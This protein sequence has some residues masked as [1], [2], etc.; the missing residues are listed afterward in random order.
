VRVADL[1]YTRKGT[2]K[3]QT[4]FNRISAKHIDFVL[5]RADDVSPV[6]AVELDDA[7]HDRDDR[8]DR[9]TFV[10][11]AFAAA[12]FPLL[13]VR[14]RAGYNAGELARSIHEAMTPMPNERPSEDQS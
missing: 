14:A 1:L 11:G 2:E 9:D 5:C 6:L 8:K 10:D 3:R 7:S 12:G 13:R 4:H